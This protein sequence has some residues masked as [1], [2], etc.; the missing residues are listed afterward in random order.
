[1]WLG[2]STLLDYVLVASVC[3]GLLTLAIL[4][5]RRFPLP[6]FALSWDWVCRLH[7]RKN[8][9]PYGIALAGSALLV[10]PH[11]PIWRA[12]FT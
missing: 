11:T 10:Y 9:V 3:G 1:M 5:L 2:F 6:Y 4:V 8:G 12:L 7:D